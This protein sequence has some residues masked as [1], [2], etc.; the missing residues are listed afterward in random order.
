[1]AVKAPVGL[2][3]PGEVSILMGRAVEPTFRPL[4]DKELKVFDRDL[5][6]YAG[7]FFKAR[8]AFSIIL[9]DR[10]FY[11]LA[12]QIACDQLAAAF[13]G[14]VPGSNEVGM[15]F[16]RPKTILGANNWFRDI[17]LPGWNDIFG[18][19][20][21]PVDLSTTSPNYGN[22]QN[23]VTVAFTKL[24]EYTTPKISEVWINIGPTNYPIWPIPLWTLTDV[25]VTSLPYGVFVGKNEK[26]YMRGNVLVPNTT[27]ATFPLGF[28]FCLGSYMVGPGQE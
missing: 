22:P 19:A 11:L 25:A 15:Q 28:T 21:N 20:S 26:F 10:D 6:K 4:T 3:R 27:I 13:G 2:I 12:A 14:A 18:S 8:D 17:G 1:M 7:S 9:E 24:G 16:I 5:V 23:R